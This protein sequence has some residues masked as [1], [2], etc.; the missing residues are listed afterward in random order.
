[1]R[2]WRRPDPKALA[3]IKSHEGVGPIKNGR[4]MVYEDSLG[5]A[6]TGY[7]RNI[8]RG[9][10]RDEVDLFFD[11]DVA[12]AYRLCRGLDYWNALDPVRRGCLVDMAYNLGSRFISGWPG[13]HAAM[14]LQDYTLAA[15]EMEWRKPSD[16]SQGR[17]PWFE[18]TKRRGQRLVR[19]ILSG[20]WPGDL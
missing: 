9:F 13:F 4:F 10:S 15:L 2:F 11:N 1:M 3:L 8:E 17:T 7:G 16:K 6:T 12:E 18:Q 20:Q 14:R 5:V 19:L